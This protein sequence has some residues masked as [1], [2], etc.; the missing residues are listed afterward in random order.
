I[1][2]PNAGGKSVALKTVGLAAFLSQCGFA[3]PAAEGSRMPVY[4]ALN[5]DLGDDQSIENDLS[6]F[7]GRLTWIRNTLVVGGLSVVEAHSKQPTTNHQ[8]L[9]LIDEAA[10]GT[11][12]EEGTALYQALM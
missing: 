5:V 8:Q 2:G 1:T 11:D 9:T 4:A 10:A 7:S 3:F 6:T 12:P